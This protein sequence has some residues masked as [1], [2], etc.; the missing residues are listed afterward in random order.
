LCEVW[1]WD[2]FRGYI[3][4]QV[5]QDPAGGCGLLVVVL[6]EKTR[7]EIHRSLSGPSNLL[8]LLSNDRGRNQGCIKRWEKEEPTGS[9]EQ[10]PAKRN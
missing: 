1:I 6:R 5:L 3:N 9:Q 4:A 10:L 7:N 2:I 8:T